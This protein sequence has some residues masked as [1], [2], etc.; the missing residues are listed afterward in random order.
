MAYMFDLWLTSLT[1]STKWIFS[2]P[3]ITQYS[4]YSQRQ[5]SKMKRTGI[6]P[7]H[8]VRAL[9]NQSSLQRKLALV[10]SLRAFNLEVELV[11]VL[12]SN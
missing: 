9:G 2:R 8:Q 10:L 11:L 4:E 7:G 6:N 3:R 12:E 1:V 5:K